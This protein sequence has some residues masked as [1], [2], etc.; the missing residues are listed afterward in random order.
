MGLCLRELYIMAFRLS[1]R[2]VQIEIVITVS[3]SIAMY[4]LIQMYIPISG[5]LAPQKPLLKLF[6]IKAVGALPSIFPALYLHDTQVVSFK[7]F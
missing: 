2:F 4:C 5:H 1:L 7:F 6:A 3:V